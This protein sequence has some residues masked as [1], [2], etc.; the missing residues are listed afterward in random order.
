MFTCHGREV[1][2]SGP[3]G[4]GKSRGCLE[5]L[6][7]RALKYAGSRGL[8]TRKERATL[9]QTALVTFN[10]E[11]QP[12]VDGV[13][14]R[15]QEQ[16]Y[17]YPNGS[18]I[19]VGGLDK[20][21]RKV[22]SGQYD[23]IYVNEATELGEV[24]WENLT[25]RLRN[26]KAPYQQIFGDCNPDAPLHWLKRRA[27]SG[28]T[29]MLESRH[30]DNPILWDAEAG[31]WTARGIE[32]IEGVLDNLTGVRK[33]RLRFGQWAAAEGMVYD[34][35]DRAKHLIDQ[36][37]IPADWPRYLAI[38]FG[39]T[40]PFVCQWWAQDPD[41]R[42]YRYREIYRTQRLVEDHAREIMDLSDGEPKPQAVICDH[43]AEDRATFEKHTG[44]T[45][46]AA[47]KAVSP[48]IQAVA[49]RFKV[50]GDGKP[51]L[52]YLRGALVAPDAALIDR[53]K[54]TCS[55]EEIEGYVW[56]TSAGRKRGEEPFKR[57]DHGMDATRYL[58]AYF[59]VKSPELFFA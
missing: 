30:E 48:G 51:R 34:G 17:R 22:M 38:D 7:L 26:G 55:E 41:G 42:L 40:N 44:L 16:E 58:V 28:K 47:H 13:R 53:K 59:D 6:H 3:A 11:V 50:A 57:D 10:V 31:Q 52:F 20:E 24:E 9:T 27:D 8:I 23:F 4:T 54:P 37:E 33:L 12:D 45:T 35:W 32:Y 56:D 15:T 39:Y 36:F 2:V 49:S 43:D 18:V 46:M 1:V 21:G 25:T 19:V 5:L 29:L 14:W